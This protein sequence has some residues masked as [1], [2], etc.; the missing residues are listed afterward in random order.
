MFSRRF[1]L[2]GA[3]LVTLNVVLWLAAPGLALR[4]AVIN[5]LFGPRMVRAQVHLKNGQDWN[6]DR[7]VVTQVS[8]TQVIL[9]EADGRIQPIPL[10]ATTKVIR[11]G[12]HLPLSM[13]AR[14]WHVVV[15]WPAIGAAESVD[16]E[17][18]P[19]AR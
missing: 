5:Q 17:K 1:V 4:K 10:A 18:I 7:G 3:A 19:K 12:R 13:L 16:V 14:R 11:L 9:R 6:V 15:T 8:A 2:L